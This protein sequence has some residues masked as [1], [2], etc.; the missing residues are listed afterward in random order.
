MKLNLVI[1][2][3]FVAAITVTEPMWQASSPPPASHEWTGAGGIH[4]RLDTGGRYGSEARI[5]REGEFY[6][7]L[8]AEAKIDA[9]LAIRGM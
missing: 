8:P 1:I 3:G 5:Y 7:A 4:W 9:L 6:V 2:L